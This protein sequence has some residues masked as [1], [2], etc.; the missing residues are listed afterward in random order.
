MALN[1]ETGSGATNSDSYN[2]IADINAYA[3]ARGL[4]FAITGADTALAE[5]AA[6]RAFVW[7]DA[8]Y[9]PYLSGY[10]TNYER[11]AQAGEF[12]RTNMYDQ[13]DI[14]QLIASDVIPVEWVA[15]HC[16]AAIREKA[17][18]GSLSPDITP[19]EI[20]ESVTVE[21]AISVDYAKGAGVSG[22][23]PIVS[24]IDNILAPLISISHGASF[25]AQAVRG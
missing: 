16:E 10:R 6:R 1:V 21:G 11:P 14:A 25:I 15:A 19:G 23:K 5:E 8:T 13:S 12:P 4:T 2:S 24:V 20:I 22:Q 7:L 3:L 17:S 18:S 9:R